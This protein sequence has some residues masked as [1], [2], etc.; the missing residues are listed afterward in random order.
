MM[1]KG[2]NVILCVLLGSFGGIFL[3]WLVTKLFTAICSKKTQNE[4]EE[5]KE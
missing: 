2:L 1:G 3:G 4:E 5:P